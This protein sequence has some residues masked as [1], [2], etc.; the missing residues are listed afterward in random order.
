V[1]RRESGTDLGSGDL[2]ARGWWP[3]LEADRRRG[4]PA[5]TYRRSGGA[6]SRRRSCSRGEGG[7]GVDN[8]GGVRPSRRALGAIT[9]GG[10]LFF[11]REERDRKI[12]Q[13]RIAT[14][15]DWGGGGWRIHWHAGPEYVRPTSQ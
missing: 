9:V 7:G 14:S 11:L 12:R 15:S 1:G 5:R 2:G 3:R 8:V 13:Q 10:K 6:G 4:A